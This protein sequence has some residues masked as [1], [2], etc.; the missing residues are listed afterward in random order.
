MRQHNRLNSIERTDDHPSEVSEAGTYGCHGLQRLSIDTG[1]MLN[2]RRACFRRSE[3]ERCLGGGVHEGIALSD[4]LHSQVRGHVWGK[5]SEERDQRGVFS[6]AARTG[7]G[8]PGQ[9]RG[10]AVAFSV[11]GRAGH[12]HGLAAGHGKVILLV[13]QVLEH[14]PVIHEQ[15][16]RIVAPAKE[17][18]ALEHMVH[19]VCVRVRQLELPLRAVESARPIEESENKLVYGGE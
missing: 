17:F 8:R 16:H 6:A 1:T 7:A 14:A 4:G 13:V 2:G 9:G 18:T 19:E 10:Q 5:P 11:E 12:D 15:C 3:R